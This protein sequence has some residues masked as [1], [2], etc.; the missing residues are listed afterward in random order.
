MTS[1]ARLTEA[2]RMRT[3]AKTQNLFHWV[4]EVGQP[5][6]VRD[7]RRLNEQCGGKGGIGFTGLGYLHC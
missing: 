2:V 1:C 5:G 6:H 4:P 3:K 7:W